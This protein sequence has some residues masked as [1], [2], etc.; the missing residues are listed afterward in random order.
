MNKRVSCLN[1]ILFGCVELSYP[2]IVSHP[3]YSNIHC[4]KYKEGEEVKEFKLL[5]NISDR[6]RE[7]GRLFSVK[8]AS[9]DKYLK[10]TEDDVVRCSRVFSAWIKNNGHKDYPLT[11]VGLHTLLM[12]MGRREA[13]E[14]MY[15]VL[16]ITGTKNNI[17]TL[18]KM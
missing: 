17:D 12:K 15:K 5:E 16:S 6:W 14:E 9:L 18:Y 3:N 1:P 13:A 8:K 7:A 2:S 11:W 4:I 10:G